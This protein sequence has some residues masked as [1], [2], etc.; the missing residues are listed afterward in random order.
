M[1]M[2]TC[3]TMAVAFGSMSTGALAAWDITPQWS[4]VPQTPIITHG[5]TH[6]T[7]TN[8]W[9]GASTAPVSFRYI[10]FDQRVFGYELG[11]DPFT[12]GPNGANDPGINSDPETYYDQF[13]NPHVISGTG[14]PGSTAGNPQS[15]GLRVLTDL[16][17]WT[18]SGFSAVPAG[19]TLDI[20]RGTQVRTAG[21]G[22]GVL[23]PLWVPLNSAGVVHVHLDSF[24]KDNLNANNPTPG[25]YMIEA[26]VESTHASALPSEPIW[27]LYN[28]GSTGVQ[29][30]DAMDWVQI[31]LV[32]EPGVAGLLLPGLLLLFRRRC[33]VGT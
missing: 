14:L 17:Y 30:K 24:L 26:R 22:T 12:Y 13:G 23:T 15:V 5:T 31:N 11:T 18:G 33:S 32:P 19:E 7:T 28:F 6:A 4:G 8:P 1:S 10:E 29:F 27:I 2:R 25:I 21:T 16:Q 20:V 9:T 3:L